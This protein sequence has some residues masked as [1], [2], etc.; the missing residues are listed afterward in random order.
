[1][2][3]RWL[4]QLGGRLAFAAIAFM[5][6]LRLGPLVLRYFVLVTGKICGWLFDVLSLVSSRVG[7][8]IEGY[9]SS[10]PARQSQGN[11]ARGRRG[12]R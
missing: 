5:M 1:M 3:T 12:G 8:R 6:L 9:L 4:G 2:R 10:L 7:P 11:R